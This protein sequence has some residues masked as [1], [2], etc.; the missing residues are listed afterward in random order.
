MRIVIVTLEDKY[1]K[2]ISTVFP[3]AVVLTG[4]ITD[5]G[6]HLPA[7]PLFYV[8]PANSLGFMDGGIDRVFSRI[9]FPGIDRAVKETIKVYGKTNKSGQRYL[10]IGSAVIVET[11]SPARG[12]YPVYLVSAPTMLLPQNVSNTRNAF[13]STLASLSVVSRERVANATLVFPLMCTGFG[14]MTVEQC[15]GQMRDAWE[16]FNTEGWQTYL[17]GVGCPPATLLR[18]PNLAQQPKLYENISWLDITP[19]QVERLG[20]LPIDGKRLGDNSMAPGY[21]G[22]N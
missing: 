20:P 3:E 18:E 10:P 13:E 6:K 12:G 9:M 11:G 1:H 4:S 22:S 15:V 5:V 16:F 2:V 19:G 14:G 21:P 8:S 7:G 17:R